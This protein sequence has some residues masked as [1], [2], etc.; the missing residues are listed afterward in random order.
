MKLT[1]GKDVI[2]KFSREEYFDF[3]DE[4][5]Y[6]DKMKYNNNIEE[7]PMVEKVVAVMEA[8]A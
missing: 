3:K 8:G 1:V 7:L 4:L 2:F 6:I 5:S